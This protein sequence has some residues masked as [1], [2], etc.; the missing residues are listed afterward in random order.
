MNE[1]APNEVRRSA[2]AGSWYPGS[3]S[4]LARNIDG[5]LS[6]VDAAPVNGELKGLVS[7]HA[8]YAYSG[9]V[10]AYAYKQLEGKTY[11]H[12]VIVSP[13]HQ[14]YGGRY[15]VTADR[16]YETPFGLVEVDADLVRELDEEV[17]LT[18]I[19]QDREHSLE[20][21]L[22]FLQR[23]LDEFTLLPVMMGEQSL[24]SCRELSTALAGV[25]RGKEAV[26]VASSDLAHLNDYH[27]VVAHDSV[28]QKFVN[29]FDPEGL[30]ASLAKSEA[31]ACGG[32]PIVTVMLTARER[33]ANRA[34]VLKYM[35]SG[36][37]TG[38]RARG[39]YTVGYLAGAVYEAA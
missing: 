1:V 2:I 10:A 4:E 9:G 6:A 13:V 25:L 12:V 39:Q 21:Q 17:D 3:A 29:D 36:D 32:G 11:P 31:Q 19:E 27:E 23:V 34:Q 14:P 16:Y 20:I 18:F 24:A 35:N 37:V 8:G 22:P 7:P 26:L 38:I 5:F 30:A 33:G 28:V 15:L